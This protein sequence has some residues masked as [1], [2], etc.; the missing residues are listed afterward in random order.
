V[1]PE[2]VTLNPIAEDPTLAPLDLVGLDPHW[3]IYLLAHDYPPPKPE[4][5]RAGSIDTEG[6]RVV[7]VKWGNRTIPIKLRLFE[8]EDPATV[9]LVPNPSFELG[10]TGWEL[11]SGSFTEPTRTQV[12]APESL[13]GNGT[14]YAMRLRA[15]KDNTA[16]ERFATAQTLTGLAGIPVVAGTTYTQSWYLY[17]ADAPERGG[18]ANFNLEINWYNAAGELLSTSSAAGIVV[19]AGETRRVTQTAAAP[20]L[21]TFCRL[22]LTGKTTTPLDVVDYY[23]DR[24]QL[25]A[26]AAASA[27]L[28]GD[29]P[30][31]D[32]S[33][34]RHAS[35]SSRPAP[36]G[37]RFARIYRDV[38]ESLDR[39]KR[40][41]SGTYRRIAPGFNPVTYDLRSLEVTETPQEDISHAMKRAEVGIAFEALPGGRGPEIQIGGNTDE[42]VKPAV[43]LL[44][45][46]I[47]GDMPALGRLQLEDRQGQLQLAAWWGIQQDNYSAAASAELFYEAESRTPVG[48]AALAA[49]GSASGAGNN[50]IRHSKLVNAWQAVLSTQAAGGGAHLS[51][52]GSYR[53]LARLSHPPINT[54]EV[55]V[56]LAW[57]Q[58]DFVNVAENDPVTFNVDERETDFSIEDLGIVTLEQAP[59][60]TTQRWEGRV[61]AKSTTNSGWVEVD[62]LLLIPIDEGSGEARAAATPP[63]AVSMVGFDAYEQTAGALTG[64]TAALGGIYVVHEGSDTDDFQVS[65]IEHLISRTAV[66]DTGELMPGI[67]GRAVGLPVNL[68]TVAMAYDFK[69]SNFNSFVQAFQFLRYIDKNNFVWVRS[70]TNEAGTQTWVD[71]NI[72]VAG[73]STYA[74]GTAY[75]GGGNRTEW[76]RLTTVLYGELFFVYLGPS[77]GTQTLLLSGVTSKL[78][79]L[80]AGGAYIGDRCGN[81]TAT[82]RWFDNLKVWEPTIDAAIYPNRMLEVRDNLVRRQD[83]EGLT[84]GEAPYEGDY[85]LVPP[86]GPEKRVSRIIAKASRNPEIDIGIDDIRAK[87]FIVPRYLMAPPT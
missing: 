70:G 68:A 2:R 36:D 7:A 41:R 52:V 83:K 55:S 4:I 11:S 42:L 47:P 37:T 28:D 76:Q 61:L 31:C 79:A 78:A 39:M 13:V 15:V 24:V 82:T 35:T 10:V 16:T 6:D 33:G 1:K 54:G 51:H 46:N 62:W 21:A 22:R 29:F 59:A 84:W 86:A 80:A 64:K 32:W 19:N 72:R 45:E 12:A 87:L 53:V 75:L 23:V 27:Y 5:V 14:D 73:A 60:G 43:S 74:T 17:V 50:V 9:N 58:G 26:G 20:A 85:L 30:G 67:S 8:P 48:L 49:N 44:A 25:E 34:A 3:G 18:L 56:R 63:P 57:T 69:A 40:E 66:S 71:F 65:A 38:F 77:G 81:A